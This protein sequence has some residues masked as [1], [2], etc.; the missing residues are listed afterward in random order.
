VSQNT[1]VAA[2][3]NTV[4]GDE[5]CLYLGSFSKKAINGP[6]AQGPTNCG[7]TQD[8]WYAVKLTK[9]RAVAAVRLSLAPVAT[10]QSRTKAEEPA[11]EYNVTW[12]NAGYGLNVSTDGLLIFKEDNQGNDAP[13]DPGFWV[14]RGKVFAWTAAF[15][16]AAPL[17][18][19][20][21]LGSFTATGVGAPT[22]PGVPICTEAAA[23]EPWY[24]TL[25]T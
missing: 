10:A 18:V 13:A 3:V 24:A 2:R 21:F 8:T 17:N 11:P 4:N 9:K 5:G 14:V 19:C 1:D 12:H 22:T 25:P 20:L 7:G 23:L 16:D 15:T 6:H